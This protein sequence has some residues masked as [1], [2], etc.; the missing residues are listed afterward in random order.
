MASIDNYI[1]EMR[2]VLERYRRLGISRQMDY[3]KFYLYSII[4]HSTAIEGSTVTETENRL[5]FDEGISAN[6]RSMGEQLMNLDLKRAY[7]LSAR[8]AGEHKPFSVDML[9]ELSAVV[10]KN[11]GGVYSTLQGEFDSSKGD[12][13]LVGVTAGAG[14][15][16]YMNYL[17]VPARLEEF[18]EE[19]NRRRE[20]L[21]AVSDEMEAYILSFDAHNVLVSIHPWVDGNGRMSRLVMNQIQFEFG[22]VPTKVMTEDKAA[23]IEALNASREEESMLP[24]RQFMFQEHIRNLNAEILRYE[25]SLEDD[26]RYRDDTKDD[27]KDGTKELSERQRVILRLIA[28]DDT[29]TIAEM[30]QKTGASSVTVKRD[31]AALQSKG[32]LRREG[33][34]KA[35]HWVIIE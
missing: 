16:S 20:A 26:V 6:G 27:T 35:G 34:R 14:G 8:W 9:K 7:E 5:L 13:R 29:I 4:T 32:L 12:L 18:C 25:K 22:L 24:F 2:A 17:K 21:I 33:G 10:M 19:I 11:T 28:G 3:D 1:K 30:T 31:I 23:Y 15:R